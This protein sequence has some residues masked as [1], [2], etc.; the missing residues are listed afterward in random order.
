M[1]SSYLFKNVLAQKYRG[2]DEMILRTRL[3]DDMDPEIHFANI[4]FTFVYL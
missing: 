4:V 2:L 1:R 3:G